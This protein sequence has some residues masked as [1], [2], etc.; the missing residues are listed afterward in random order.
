MKHAIAVDSDDVWHG[1]FHVGSTR[2]SP[3]S[4]PQ[5]PPSLP[6]IS[7]TKSSVLKTA[8]QVLPSHSR[9]DQ[10]PPIQSIKYPSTPSPST[11]LATP[12]SNENTIQALLTSY[13]PIDTPTTLPS[14]ST[15]PNDNLKLGFGIGLGSLLLLIIGAASIWWWE[16]RHARAHKYEE[17]GESFVF[18][19]TARADWLDRIRF[20][21]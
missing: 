19:V 12:V 5:P 13:S 2:P 8:G 14:T 18:F 17:A 11:T 7:S 6:S 16:R 15:P 4:T 21:R 20:W 1:K 10:A 9:P 3:S